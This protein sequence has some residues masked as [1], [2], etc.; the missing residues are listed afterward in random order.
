MNKV[1]NK[2]QIFF[3]IFSVNMDRETLDQKFSRMKT[4]QKN[5]Q[6]MPF[7]S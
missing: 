4:K 3:S 2:Q 5:Q 7:L 6:K 1:P